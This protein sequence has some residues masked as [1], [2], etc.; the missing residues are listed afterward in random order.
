MVTVEAFDM[1]IT[2]LF[3]SLL[4][5]WGHGEISESLMDLAGIVAAGIGNPRER[6]NGGSWHW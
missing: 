1:C 4:L 6:I 3:R 2:E 5:F